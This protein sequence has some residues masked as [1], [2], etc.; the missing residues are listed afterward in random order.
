MSANPPDTALQRLNYF[1]GQRLV[2]NDLRTEQ[3][4]HIGMRHVLNRS[5]YSP[6][7]VVGLEVQP[8]QS[9]PPNP[10]DK[11]R[12]IVKRGL[13][14]DDQGRD[15]YVPFDVV[16]QVTGAPRS[17]PG[18][19]VGNL[20]VVSY[21][22]TRQFPVQEACTIGAPCAPCSGSLAWGAPT[23]IVADVVFEFVDTWPSA[24]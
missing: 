2:A 23:R 15:L 3:D 4:Y 5:L 14:F 10:Q 6:G 17:A 19:V 13:A 12:V 1:N 16:V 21:L 9:N 18:V 20:L 24:D 8:A 11:H 22:E 7:I